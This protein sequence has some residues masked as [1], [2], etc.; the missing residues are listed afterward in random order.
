MALFNGLS[1]AGRW[2]SE[3]GSNFLDGG[4]HFYNTYECA[5]GRHLAVGAIEPNFYAELCKLLQIEDPAFGAQHDPAAWPALTQKLAALFRGRPRDEWMRLL[6]HT[7]ACV[8]P[9]LD[10][11]EAPMHPHNLARATS[12]IVDGVRQ[13]VP[14]PRF[15]RTPGAIQGPPAPADHHRDAILA[16]WGIGSRVD[17][18]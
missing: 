8:S 1:A 14:A 9:V 11:E 15:S 17:R 13:P 12:T 2:S 16:D 6:E 10:L 5:D 4:A 7:D 3:R 18:R